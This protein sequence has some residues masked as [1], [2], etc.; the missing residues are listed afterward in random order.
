M[1]TS[2]QKAVRIIKY[3]LFIPE[4][5]AETSQIFLTEITSS[6][7]SS[8]LSSA[9]RNLDQIVGPPCRRSTHGAS[10]G[11]WLDI[12]FILIDRLINH[13]LIKL[14]EIEIKK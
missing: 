11:T 14:I 8:P 10:S 7:S 3:L 5:V 1:I 9:S 13:K 2:N 12:L 6:S 4:R